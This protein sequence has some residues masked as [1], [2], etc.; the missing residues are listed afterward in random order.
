M[1][2]LKILVFVI[3]SIWF[4][5]Y[6]AI[7]QEE[8]EVEEIEE[9]VEENLQGPETITGTFDGFEGDHYSFNYTNE[10]DEE[11]SIL[12]DK[13]TPEVLKMYNLKD[14]KYIGKTFEITFISESQTEVDEDGDKQEFIKRRI[15]VLKPLD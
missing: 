3:T 1:K 10:E 5:S 4:C 2:N 9:I 7:A 6:T 11:D 12:F 15:T 14:K 8:E 13:I